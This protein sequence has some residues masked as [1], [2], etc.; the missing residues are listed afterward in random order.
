MWLYPSSLGNVVTLGSA[1]SARPLNIS[2]YILATRRSV[3]ARLGSFKSRP[4]LDRM[5][6]TWGG[7]RELYPTFPLLPPF[8][9]D[10]SVPPP[11]RLANLAWIAANSDGHRRFHA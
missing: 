3:S 4:R 5:P 6:R 10:V 11:P 8:G 1:P 9:D 7:K 2:R